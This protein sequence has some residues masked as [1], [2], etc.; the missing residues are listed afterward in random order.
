MKICAI[1]NITKFKLSLTIIFLWVC[2]FSCQ[3][4]N[5]MMLPKD[6]NN[7]YISEDLAENIAEKITLN[8]ERTEKTHLHRKVKSITCIPQVENQKNSYYIINYEKGGVLS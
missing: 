3:E 4:E 5:S 7:T 1:K 2:T 6:S 8:T